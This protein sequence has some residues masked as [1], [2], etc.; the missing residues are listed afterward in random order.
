LVFLFLSLENQ[1]MS[2]MLMEDRRIGS[3]L[4]GIM[5]VINEI[6]FFISHASGDQASGT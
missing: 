6:I 1:V 3:P 4:L 2:Y 5:K